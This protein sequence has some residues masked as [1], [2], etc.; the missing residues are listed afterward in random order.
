[1]EG[2]TIAETIF[3]DT[4][5][6]G[7]KVASHTCAR[8]VVSHMGVLISSSLRH[9]SKFFLFSRL[10]S[11][12][13]KRSGCYFS[14]SLNNGRETNVCTREGKQ[15]AKRPSTNDRANEGRWSLKAHKAREF[16]FLSFLFPFF[17]DGVYGAAATSNF[18]YRLG[19]AARLHVAPFSFFLSLGLFF[20]NMYVSEYEAREEWVTGN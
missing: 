13:G 9:G 2:F 1:M 8:Q 15:N 12:P 6:Y 19:N 7:S 17:S 5:Y 16:F 4:L 20:S 11:E 18:G 3:F 14:C 10:W